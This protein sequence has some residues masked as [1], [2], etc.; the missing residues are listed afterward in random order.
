MQPA[1]LIEAR[2]ALPVAC[3]GDGQ[4]PERLKG[5]DCKSVGFAYVGSNPTLSTIFPNHAMNEIAVPRL[6]SAGLLLAIRWH[7][8]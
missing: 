4:V 6:L 5:T 7:L 3:I 2:A 8:A 1:R